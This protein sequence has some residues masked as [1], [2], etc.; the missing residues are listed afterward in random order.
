MLLSLLQ[1]AASCSQFISHVTLAP[2]KA[3]SG[4]KPVKKQYSLL[5]ESWPR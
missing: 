4:G 1:K 5:P 3:M 2:H